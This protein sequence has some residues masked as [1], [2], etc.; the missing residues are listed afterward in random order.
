MVLVTGYYV[1]L[2]SKMLQENRKQV[3][4]MQKPTV[5]IFPDSMV[6]G[7]IGLFTLSISNTGLSDV[8]NIG[9]YEDYFVSITSKEKSTIFY[10]FGPLLTPKTVIQSLKRGKTKDFQ[11]NF[12]NGYK[13]MEKFYNNNVSGSR[14]RIVRLTVRYE[15]KVDGKKFSL[16]KAYLIAGSGDA[17]FDQSERGMTNPYFPITFDQ[18]KALLGVIND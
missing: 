6:K 8:T 15:R 5:R 1:H 17:L 2:T 3:E 14:M 12:K 7:E 13:N 18:I 9:I 11:I 16:L 10:P 4:V